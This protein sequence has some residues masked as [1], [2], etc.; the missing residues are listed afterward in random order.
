MLTIGPSHV[1]MTPWSSLTRFRAQNTILTPLEANRRAYPW[2]WLE[3]QGFRE[4]LNFLKDWATKL[5]F[6]A[7]DVLF[8]TACGLQ[9][10]LQALGTCATVPGLS[11]ARPMT[12]VSALQAILKQIM[13]SISLKDLYCS[14]EGILQYFKKMMKIM[15][16]F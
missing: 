13:W 16:K 8:C 3:N 14:L 12:L 15:Q 11:N 7:L 2:I 1:L 5:H 10:T 4:I 6:P 9:T